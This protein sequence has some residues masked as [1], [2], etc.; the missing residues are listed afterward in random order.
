MVIVSIVT[1]VDLE[2]RID[3]MNG[4]LIFY[5]ILTSVIEE[6]LSLI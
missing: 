5:Q 2:N 4:F 3:F 6:T 1:F